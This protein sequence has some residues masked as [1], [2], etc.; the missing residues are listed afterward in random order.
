MYKLRLTRREK[1]KLMRARW[2][3]LLLSV[4]G[5]A[6]VVWL[7]WIRPIQQES[8][9]DSFEKCVSAG[10]PIQESYPEVCLTRDGKRFVNPKQDS[11]RKASQEQSEELVPP[12]NP[13]L[14]RL[15]VEEWGIRVPLTNETFD[16]SYNYVDNGDSQRVRFSYKR[17]QKLG[18]CKG[19]IGLTLT[20]S[21]LQNAAPF[22]AEKPAPTAKVDKF[23][24]YVTYA[25]KPCYDPN[26]VEQAA[27]VKAMAGEL[28]LTQATANLLSKL[29]ATPKEQ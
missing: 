25:D 1:K 18:V 17:L 23:Y 19:D 12:S 11:A 15:D 6:G 24:Y 5:V 14:L 9:I 3:V 28:T 20:R 7:A 16:L 27:L 13:A 10:N 22:T 4:L 29:I 2:L 8:N 26:N 21:V